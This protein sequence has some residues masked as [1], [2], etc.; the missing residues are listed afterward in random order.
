MLKQYIE[1]ED[2]EQSDQLNDASQVCAI[3][4]TDMA[5]EESND[6]V[7]EGLIETLSHE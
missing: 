7:I 4:V 2:D 1:R 3:S 6:E 5:S